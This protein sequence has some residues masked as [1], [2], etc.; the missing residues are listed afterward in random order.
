M[1]SVAGKCCRG[2]PR[3]CA[4]LAFVGP[5]MLIVDGLRLDDSIVS[6][7]GVSETP[8]GFSK[9]LKSGDAVCMACHQENKAFCISTQ[10]CMDPECTNI[11]DTVDLGEE[12]PPT[13]VIDSIHRAVH[14]GV[15]GMDLPKDAG[16]ASSTVLNEIGLPAA[17]LSS[18]RDIL[19]AEG[20]SVG[21]KV[22][23]KKP[24]A[25]WKLVEGPDRSRAR[26]RPKTGPVGSGGPGGRDGRNSRSPSAEESRRQFLDFRH[27]RHAG[28]LQE[29]EDARSRR[30]RREV[31]A[32]KEVHPSRRCGRPC[33]PCV[34]ARRRRSVCSR[35]RGGDCYSRGPPGGCRRR[36]P[37]PRPRRKDCR[38]RRP[39]PCREELE[40]DEDYCEPCC[41]EYDDLEDDDDYC[42]PCCECDDVQEDDFSEDFPPPPFEPEGGC[43]EGCGDGCDCFGSSLEQGAAQRRIRTDRA[44]GQEAPSQS[45]IRRERAHEQDAA[46]QNRIRR[47]QE[48]VRLKR[49]HIERA[50]E[51]DARASTWRPSV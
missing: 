30:D 1:D 21:R 10:G 31:D 7:K 45:R 29:D 12:C 20:S 2:I 15:D 14:L 40:D 32:E 26:D 22:F 44:H 47:E 3:S 48:A 43:D 38:V 39:C 19:R 51:Q 25:T 5:F 49:I 35:R 11:D 24:L 50:Y 13:E 6:D 9:Y 33:S 37:C 42:E 17:P 46:S 41:E 28:A 27:R 36:H 16:V 8:H 18:E 34:Q 23:A 4:A